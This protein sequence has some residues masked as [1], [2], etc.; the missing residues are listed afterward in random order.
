MRTV[1]CAPRSRGGDRPPW[2]PAGARGRSRKRG[3]GWRAASPVSQ[4]GRDVPDVAEVVAHSASA[5]SVGL[6]LRRGDRCRTVA[7]RQPVR[8]IGVLNV[9][10]DRGYLAHRGWVGAWLDVEGIDWERVEA[11][12]VEA[13]RLAAPAPWQRTSTRANE[14]G[15]LRRLSPPRASTSSSPRRVRT[16][17]GMNTAA[18][19]RPSLPDECE[20]AQPVTPAP[21]SDDAR[22]RTS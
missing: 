8:R 9:D 1:V 16:I 12:L 2:S 21:A 6:V 19:P 20:H 13:Y 22:E 10:V 4:V 11:L 14:T 3:H 7:E 18:D 5:F 15:R 17:P